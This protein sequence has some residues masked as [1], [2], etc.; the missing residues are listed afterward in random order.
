MYMNLHTRHSNHYWL[1][2][3]YSNTLKSVDVNFFEVVITSTKLFILNPSLI[4]KVD[5]NKKKVAV[6]L[7]ARKHTYFICSPEHRV[8]KV[9]YCDYVV[10]NFYLG[11]PR[12]KTYQTQ[13]G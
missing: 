2:I 6:R 10:F 7:E 5:R 1:S 12:L 13:N 3:V 11:L 4:C 9:R 8:L